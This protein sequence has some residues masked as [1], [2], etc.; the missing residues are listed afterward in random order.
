M[1][2]FERVDSPAKS[3]SCVTDFTART[4][5]CPEQRNGIQKFVLKIEVR[6]QTV[7]F[8]IQYMQV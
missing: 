4:F 8:F 3:K 6:D 2:G 1:D 5:I 7:S